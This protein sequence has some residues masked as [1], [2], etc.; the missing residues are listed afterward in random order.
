LFWF[1][2]QQLGIRIFSVKVK[3]IH[4]RHLVISYSFA[5]QKRI[6]ENFDFYNN[7]VNFKIKLMQV[8]Y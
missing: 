5:R 2:I 6:F 4:V 3:M 8:S 7:H 1:L